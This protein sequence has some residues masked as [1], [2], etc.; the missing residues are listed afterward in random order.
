MR[1]VVQKGDTVLKI[2]NRF[3]IGVTAL[4]SANPALMRRTYLIPGQVVTVPE[5]VVSY[6]I[7][8]GD[9]LYCIAK[10]FGVAPQDL[11]EA[12]P[13][14]KSLAPEAELISGTVLVIPHVHT[15]RIV[16][17]DAEYTPYDLTRNAAML[18]GRYPFLQIRTIGHSV[19]GKPLYAIRLGQ[20]PKEAFYSGAWHANEWITA[21]V[22]MKFV[23][24]MARAYAQKE[25]LRGYD[26]EEWWHRFSVWVMPMVNPDGV[27][28]SLLGIDCSHPYYQEVMAIN[29]G[30]HNFTGWTANIRGVD[31]NHQWPALWEEEAKTSPKAPAPRHYGGR[32]PLSEPEAQAVYEFTNERN[33]LG[34]LAYHAQGQEIFWGFQHMEPKGSEEIVR[35]MQTVSTYTPIHTADSFA[36]YKD[37]FIQQY[38]RPGYTI[39]VGIGVN[40]VPLAQFDMIYNQNQPILLEAPLL[41]EQY[42]H[43]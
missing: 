2:A 15:E 8:S 3:G 24:D 4:L 36:G 31:L 19:M 33:F 16:D 13:S 12:N 37:W 1:Y 38:R 18:K 35:R 27:E 39:E 41:F 6:E 20:G 25:T 21:S 22:L 40:P 26:I 43:F 42:V 32:H 9:T 30:T 23:E 10:N 17:T 7:Q 34:V 14:L 29:N 5:A 11:Q 28:L